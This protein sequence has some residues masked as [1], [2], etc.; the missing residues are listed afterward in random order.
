MVMEQAEE[1]NDDPMNVSV[2]DM[3]CLLEQEE[4]S[5]MAVVEDM[6]ELSEEKQMAKGFEEKYGDET[7]E[8]SDLKSYAI[9]EDTKS[10]KNKLKME[11]KKQKQDLE[12]LFDFETW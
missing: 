2:D 10:W 11:A 8:H 1:K 12:N 5:I 3:I 9:L 6:E 7:D 4:W